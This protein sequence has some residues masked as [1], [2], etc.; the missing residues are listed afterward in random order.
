MTEHIQAID[1]FVAELV[2]TSL[3]PRAAI[4]CLVLEHVISRLKTEQITS[5]FSVPEFMPHAGS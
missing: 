4:S 5:E 2:L 1:R 3:S